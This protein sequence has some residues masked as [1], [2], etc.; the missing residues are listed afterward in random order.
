M[1][2]VTAAQD[3]QEGTKL[4]KEMD[5][6]KKKE[7]SLEKEKNLTDLQQCRGNIKAKRLKLLSI[8]SALIMKS[9]SFSHNNGIP[10]IMWRKCF[11]DYISTQRSKS[12]SEDGK[13][14]YEK[15][16]KESIQFYEYVI[17][18]LEERLKADYNKISNFEESN[19]NSSSSRFSQSIDSIPSLSEPPI[20]PAASC[21]HRLYISL[22]DLCRYTGSLSDPPDFS[23]SENAYT[24]SIK[25][26]PISG[27]SYNQL[28]VIHQLKGNFLNALFYYVLAVTV[29]EKFD[30]ANNN[31]KRC[32]QTSVK[33]K[34]EMEETKRYILQRFIEYSG[35][36]ICISE[37]DIDDIQSS[38]EETEI[39]DFFSRAVREIMFSEGV[40][41]KI[42]TISIHVL[43]QKPTRFLKFFRGFLLQ[44]AVGVNNSVSKIVKNKDNKHGRKGKTIKF[45]GIFWIAMWYFKE[46]EGGEE[47]VGG[48]EE[49]VRI[50]LLETVSML[51]SHSERSADWAI[52]TTLFNGLRSLNLPETKSF[53]KTYVKELFELRAYEPLGGWKEAQLAMRA[54]KPC[55]DDEGNKRRVKS[56]LDFADWA[57]QAG[58]V[59]RDVAGDYVFCEERGEPQFV[60]TETSATKMEEEEEEEVKKEDEVSEVMHV[61]M[62]EG[63]DDEEQIVFKPQIQEKEG[64]EGER[65]KDQDDGDVEPFG[66]N[67]D[68]DDYVIVN[69]ENLNN[70]QAPISGA[71]L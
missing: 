14:V 31:F 43:H 48:L 55:D 32:W 23:P 59:K 38:A 26:L 33:K 45:L 9:P 51:T 34:V 10:T 61:K 54:D 21:L 42:L 37:E 66:A 3:W 62:G 6:L 17:E 18:K 5:R 68:D 52:L 40:L 12:K 44:M 8:T 39:M 11:Y 64:E 58:F 16:L 53:T 41:M 63:E 13:A 24:A 20:P 29:P 47:R 46:G 69:M 1:A 27:N 19:D 70:L 35:R 36:V 65:D 7:K 49:E 67:D 60:Y 25:H 15:T 22:G 57:V 4:E 28:G 2:N 56:V 30:T 71:P 50:L